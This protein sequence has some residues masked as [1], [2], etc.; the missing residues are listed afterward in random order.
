MITGTQVIVSAI[1]LAACPI[2]LAHNVDAQHEAEREICA[3]ADRC[4]A[5]Y[6]A[7]DKNDVLD[8]GMQPPGAA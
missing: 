6:I 8:V 4:T 7:G 1:L 3:V 5:A 2:V